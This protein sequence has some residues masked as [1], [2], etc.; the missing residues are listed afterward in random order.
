MKKSILSFVAAIIA[1]VSAATAIPSQN[2][3]SSASV[4]QNVTT[5]TTTSSSSKTETTTNSTTSKSSS[6]K[7][8]STTTSPSSSTTNK[9][10]S[11]TSTTNSTPAKTETTLTAVNKGKSE[12]PV[13]SGIT[14]ETILKYETAKTDFVNSIR[15]NG[16]TAVYNF[17]TV[18]S[19]GFGKDGTELPIEAEYGLTAYMDG[20]TIRLRAYNN[21]GKTVSASYGYIENLDSNN[22]GR[23]SI[24]V[25]N[26]FTGI[27]TD[28]YI[29]GLYRIQADFSTGKTAAL[30]FYVNGTKTYLCNAAVT[31]DGTIS[32]WNSR[33]NAVGKVLAAGGIT[34]GNNLTLEKFCYP[35][36]VFDPVKYGV[37]TNDTPLWTELSKS[38]VKEDWSDERKVYTFYSW[39]EENLAYDFYEAKNLTY[40]RASTYNDHSGTYNVW[41]TKAGVCFDFT[42]ILAIMC[43]ANGIPAGCITSNS[44]N[45]TWNIVYING[46]W[47]EIDCTQGSLYGV[48]GK[49]LNVR[50]ATGCKEYCKFLNIIPMGT[51]SLPTDAVANES[52]QIDTNRVS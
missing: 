48:Y 4:T 46:R 2:E 50:K 34:P 42:N 19:T 29:N 36:K 17:N 12:L 37:Y 8:E 45:H 49:E 6:N 3:S 32:L 25:N 31:T 9:P 11:S 26:S 44:M 47:T 22:G 24:N 39:I 28:K 30:Y 43:R 16:V 51:A 41:N 23:I 18:M 1:T 5:S 35:S 7:S 14:N 10:E 20:R 52:L 13:V 21:S 38:L 27:A 33:R 40:S 15:K